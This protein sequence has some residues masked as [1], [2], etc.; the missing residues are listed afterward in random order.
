MRKKLSAFLAFLAGT[1]FLV[2]PAAMAGISVTGISPSS[3]EAGADVHCTVTGTFNVPLNVDVSGTIYEA[4]EFTL[5]NGVDPPIPGTTDAAS[6]TATLA[7]VTF[8]LP[9]DCPAV[10]YRLRASQ[11][12]RIWIIANTHRASLPDGFQVVPTILSLSPFISTAGV[13]DL[14]VTVNGGNFVDSSA[15]VD[16]SRVRWNGETLATTFVSA[17]RLTAIVP[18]AKLTAAGTADVTVMNVS[19]GTISAAYAFKIDTTKPTTD[20]INAVSVKRKQTA[21]LKFRV[22]EPAGHSPSAQVVLVVKPVKGGKAVK[23]ITLGDVPMNVTQTSSFKVTFKTGSYKWYVY[24][25]DLAG[26]TQANVDAAKFT[27]K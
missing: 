13:G 1:M 24:A 23:T 4:P 9:V 5:D 15:D 2:V 19:A 3:G 21:K 12:Y 6:V 16:G 7:N 14:T 26:N 20:A 11:L 27:V 25:T 10:R 8:V 22:S 17:T 18:A